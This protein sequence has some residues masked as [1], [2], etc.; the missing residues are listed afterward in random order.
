MITIPYDEV[1]AAGRVLVYCED[2]RQGYAS[3][4]DVCIPLESVTS[5][6]FLGLYAKNRTASDPLTATEIV[7]GFTDREIISKASEI[8]AEQKR[9]KNGI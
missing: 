2:C 3:N 4:I 8:W 6:I 7:F 5:E 1:S 9:G